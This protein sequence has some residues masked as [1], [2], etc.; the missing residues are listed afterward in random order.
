MDEQ[1]DNVSGYSKLS[2]L[3]VLQNGKENVADED[4]LEDFDDSD[5][6]SDDGYGNVVKSVPVNRNTVF[7]L[8]RV[9][10]SNLING[11]ARRDGSGLA[12]LTRRLSINSAPALTSEEVKDD[13]EAP[14]R[15][16]EPRKRRLL[17]PVHL[18]QR[19]LLMEDVAVGT[20]TNASAPPRGRKDVDN[21]VEEAFN[22]LAR[23]ITPH[24]GPSS[25]RPP[26][27]STRFRAKR[28]SS[29][30]TATED[31]SIPSV[32]LST[33]TFVENTQ[34]DEHGR[35]TFVPPN[36][37]NF[38]FDGDERNQLFHVV[39]QDQR[40]L[41]SSL[42][43]D[44]DSMDALDRVPPVGSPRSIMLKPAGILNTSNPAV[45]GPVPPR[46]PKGEPFGRRISRNARTPDSGH[47]TPRF[48]YGAR[49]NMENDDEDDDEQ[50]NRIMKMVKRMS[51]ND[52][53]EET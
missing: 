51:S 15:R 50:M 33:V 3:A 2:Q 20:T 16:H 37:L 1:E 11:T 26:P 36:E 22:R 40:S 10:T 47:V 43:D 28:L 52:M 24:S 41:S 29:S 44:A 39:H 19:Q 32:H 53:T 13:A 38:S 46:Q 23:S 8:P 12:P 30:G 17:P 48:S 49:R 27:T 35:D 7:Q 4:S 21:A 14:R 6:S 34:L 31:P 25:P 5:S 42:N 45:N 18:P 9:S